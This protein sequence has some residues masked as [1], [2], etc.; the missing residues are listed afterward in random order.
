[1]PALRPDF[2]GE[3]KVVVPA[4]EFESPAQ[5]NEAEKL[6]W[7]KDFGRDSSFNDHVVPMIIDGKSQRFIVGLRGQVDHLSAIAGVYPH[8][9]SF[10]NPASLVVVENTK[11]NKAV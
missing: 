1:M 5:F 9:V 11:P 8:T 7:K 6:L 3:A 2:L 10:P 4:D